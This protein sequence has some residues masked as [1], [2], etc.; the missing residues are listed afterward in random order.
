MPARPGAP[1][2]LPL[3]RPVPPQVAWRGPSHPNALVVSE[4]PGSRCIMDSPLGERL[5]R[6]NRRQHGT[7]V[8]VTKGSDNC[9]RTIS[10]CQPSRELS[11]HDERESG[12]FAMVHQAATRACARARRNHACF[13]SGMEA[14]STWSCYRTREMRNGDARMA[15]MLRTRPMHLRTAIVVALAG[16]R[17][18]DG[19][20]HGGRERASSP[21]VNLGRSV[22][23]RAWPSKPGAPRPCCRSARPGS[24]AFLPD[25]SWFLF[26]GLSRRSSPKGVP[27]FRP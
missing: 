21:F 8:V 2:V 14:Q 11:F 19:G 13:L 6:R 22:R 17:V 16:A 7:A 12:D 20:S 18:H 10:N 15:P 27:R 4:E 3:P 5:A 25:E 24:C 1:F 9:D 26:C 23:V